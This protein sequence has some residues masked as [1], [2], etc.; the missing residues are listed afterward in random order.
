M[1]SVVFGLF[2]FSHMLSSEDFLFTSGV[3]NLIMREL[4]G[5]QF[6]LIGLGAP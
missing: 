6:G 5:G 3:Q 4:V 2:A 1:W